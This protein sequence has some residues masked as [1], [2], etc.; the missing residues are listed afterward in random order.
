MLSVTARKKA[1]Y[2]KF[3]EDGLTGGIPPEFGSSG[4][5][6]SKYVYHGKPEKTFRD[7]FGGDNPF[8]GERNG[9]YAEGAYSNAVLI[10]LT[11]E[12]SFPDFLTN[13]TPLQFGGLQPGAVKTQGPQIERDLHLSLDDLF[14]G[15]SKHIK[16]SHRVRAIVLE[17][18]IFL[19]P[20]AYS[21]ILFLSFLSDLF[22]RL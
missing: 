6:S 1:T 15:C 16:I 12:Y 20:T 9:P 14:H 3:G 19:H 5:W 11:K 22:T 18:T 7:F 13:D 21:F 4:A 10:I 8:A 17:M 2:D